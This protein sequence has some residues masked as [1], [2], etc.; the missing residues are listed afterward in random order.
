M[1][2][3]HHHHHH[4]H[5]RNSQHSQHQTQPNEDSGS[6]QCIDKHVS[7]LRRSISDNAGVLDQS[8]LLKRRHA[9]DVSTIRAILNIDEDYDESVIEDE[10]FGDD[11]HEYRVSSSPISACSPNASFQVPITTVESVESI[12]DYRHRHR[13]HSNDSE[14]LE[15]VDEL[16]LDNNFIHHDMKADEVERVRAGSHK[17]VGSVHGDDDDD[18]DVL[19]DSFFNNVIGNEEEVMSMVVD[20]MVAHQTFSR[21]SSSSS[22]ASATATSK[23]TFIKRRLDKTPLLS[24]ALEYLSGGSDTES[25][26][27]GT[28]AP[29]SQPKKSKHHLR[30]RPPDNDKQHFHRRST[31]RNRSCY[32][33]THTNNDMPKNSRMEPIGNLLL[34]PSPPPPPPNQLHSNLL[35]KSNS[36][37]TSPRIASPTADRSPPQENFVSPLGLTHRSNTSSTHSSNESRRSSMYHLKRSP[38]ADVSKTLVG[39]SRVRRHSISHL[40]RQSTLSEETSGL[41]PK[42]NHSHHLHVP[43]SASKSSRKGHLLPSINTKSNSSP[44]KLMTSLG[45]LSPPRMQSQLHRTTKASLDSFRPKLLSNSPFSSQS[46][47]ALSPSQLQFGNTHFSDESVLDETSYVDEDYDYTDVDEDTNLS[48]SYLDGAVDEERRKNE[49]LH[50]SA[51]VDVDI[52]VLSMD[53]VVPRTTSLL[54]P[55]SVDNYEG[56]SL[57]TS[58]RKKRHTTL[59]SKS[60]NDVHGMGRKHSPKKRSSNSSSSAKLKNSPQRKRQ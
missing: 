11:E 7:K 35:K 5:H 58:K 8:H 23:T 2:A 55:S 27:G 4:H 59:R 22:K 18:D 50:L 16:L 33:S 1:R 51:D 53:D 15:V 13:T 32:D 54:V 39:S 48:A 46:T 41:N 60:H 56:G 36:F 29:I 6:N 38:N 19:E 45:I 34:S 17:K 25:F 26:V 31:S 28:N 24:P 40:P 49:W 37:T 30:P 9:S 57:K 42:P 14:A 10:Y 44:S 43:R 3:H 21:T 52:S 12:I 47:D 20:P